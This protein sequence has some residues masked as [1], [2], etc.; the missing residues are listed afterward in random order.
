MRAWWHPERHRDRKGLLRIRH[1]ILQAVRRWFLDQDFIEVEPGALQVSPGN[2]THLHAFATKLVGSEGR[3]RAMYLHTSPEFAC[4]KLLAAG[5][6]RIFAFSH[7]YRNREAGP[8][9]APEFTM[10]EWYRADTPYE[11]AMIDCLAIAR[12]AATYAG[13]DA[14]G[15]RGKECSPLALEKTTRVDEAFGRRG[16]DLLA[17]LSEAGADAAELRRQAA[18]QDPALARFEDWSSLFSAILVEI[19]KG[20]GDG[21]LELLIEYPAVESALARACPHDP[22]VAERF[23]L[24]AAGIELA[25]GF[26]ELTDARLLREKLEAQMEARQAIYGERYPIDDDFI[27]AVGMM[28]PASGCALGFDRLVMLAAGAR[29]VNDVIWTPTVT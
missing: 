14:W 19:E 3:E 4:K 9:H 12:L 26:G 16:Y 23:E 7:V 5:E 8:L 20:L 11:R 17:T 29:S 6:K 25:N 2:E 15:W 24:F 28:P 18:R 1:G 13:R 22:R 27:E 21:A 10:L